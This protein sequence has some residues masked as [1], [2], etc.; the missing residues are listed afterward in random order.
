MGLYGA[1][2]DVFLEA[3]G[4]LLTAQF[5][6]RTQALHAAGEVIDIFP[7][8]PDCRLRRSERVPRQP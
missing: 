6:T 1:R 8:R 2:R 4:E 5:W 3:H 7:Y